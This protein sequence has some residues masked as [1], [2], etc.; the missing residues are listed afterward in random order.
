LRIK[1]LGNSGIPELVPYLP[2]RVESIKLRGP[3]L[4]IASNNT[5]RKEQ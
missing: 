3:T 4:G 5:V 2:G 1:E